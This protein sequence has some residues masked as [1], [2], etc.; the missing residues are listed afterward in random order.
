V[1]R[2]CIIRQLKNTPECS[3]RLA[4]QQRD[5]L[6]LKSA[7]NYRSEIDYLNI[8]ALQIGPIT[9]LYPTCP[10]KK[11]KDETHGLRCTDG[12]VVVLDHFEDPPDLI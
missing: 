1:P 10:A 7:F 4:Q 12:R 9:T 5:A 6:S 8:P 2:E 11:W 3:Q